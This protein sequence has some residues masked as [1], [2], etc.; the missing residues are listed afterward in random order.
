MTEERR[1]KMEEGRKKK[2]DRR[3]KENGISHTWIVRGRS[4][5]RG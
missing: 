5:E 3:K 4:R 1:H 2:E